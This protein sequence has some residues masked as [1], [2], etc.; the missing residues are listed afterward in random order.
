[1]PGTDR[2]EARE[3]GGAVRS[4]AGTQRPE[5]AGPSTPAEADRPTRA[6]LTVGL[7]TVIALVVGL[8]TRGAGVVGIAVLFVL[9]VPL[10]KLF[11]LRPQRVFRRGF[12]TDMTHLLV[13]NVLITLGVLVAVVVAMIPFFWG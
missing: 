13:N 5:A 10:E 2:R 6:G 1:M 7:I 9:F 3:R 4:T 8:V 11:A 12:L